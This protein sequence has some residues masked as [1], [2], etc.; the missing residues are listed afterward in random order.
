MLSVILHG[1]S[2]FFGFF[3]SLF[4][5]KKPFDAK[6][7]VEEEHTKES[8]IQKGQRFLVLYNPVSGTGRAR[9]VLE[10][11]VL[12]ILNELE[13]VS[14]VKPTLGPNFA[15]EFLTQHIQKPSFS[16]D[17][18]IVISGDGMLSQVINGVSDGYQGDTEKIKHFFQNCPLVPIPAGTSNGITASFDIFNLETSMRRLVQTK[19]PRLIRLLKCILLKNKTEE[20]TSLNIAN[21][22]DNVVDREIWAIQHI[23]WATTAEHDYW[24]EVRFRKLPHAIKTTL[25]PLIAIGQQYFFRFRLTMKAGSPFQLQPN[26][27]PTAKPWEKVAPESV[28]MENVLMEGNIVTAMNVS[29]ASPEIHFAP[30]SRYF[31][32]S[33]SISLIF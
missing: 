5:R 32:L 30:F 29:H 4:F 22:E 16:Y 28:E 2:V 17:G 12:P 14:D 31:L 25:A 13:V 19:H 27:S 6:K 33:E 1:L 9:A 8:F 15:R 20:L 26:D 21:E 24:Q 3:L 10:S 11:Y 23:S 7:I 18:L